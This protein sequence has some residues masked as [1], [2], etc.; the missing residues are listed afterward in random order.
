MFRRLKALSPLVLAAAALLLPAQAAGARDHGQGRRLFS[1]APKGLKVG[2]APSSLAVLE[3]EDGYDDLFVGTAGAE[4]IEEIDNHDGRLTRP[5][6]APV[7]ASPSALALQEPAFQG[8]NSIM[9]VSA[10]TDTARLFDLR[11]SRDG[12]ATFAPVG[13][14]AVGAGPAAVLAYGFE[15]TSE[16]PEGTLEEHPGAQFVVAN[17]GSDDLSLIGRSRDDR[18]SVVATV[19]VGDAPVALASDES[20]SQL[21][22]A[23][24]GS[25]TVTWLYDFISNGQ[26]Y[27]QTVAVGGEPV[28]VAIGDLVSG[29]YRDREAAVLDADS[30]RVLIVDRPRQVVG[31]PF[32][33]YRVVASYAAGRRPVALLAADLDERQGS[34]LAVVDSGSRGVRLLLNRGAGRFVDGGA[35]PAGRDPVA[36]API[37]YGPRF[38]PDLAIADRGSDELRFLVHNEFGRC[39]GRPARLRVG[40]AGRDDFGGSDEP[41]EMKGLAGDDRLAAS[42]GDDCIRGEAGEDYL[43]GFGGDD[44]LWPGPGKDEADGGSG[45]DTIFAAGGGADLVECGGGDDTAYVDRADRVRHCERER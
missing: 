2:D 10:A 20:F 35:Y 11:F 25:G 44:R 36:I 7:G 1:L 45:D 3:T 34:D 38:G 31:Q 8:L 9:A 28:A 27:S 14:V 39:N 40:T 6:S 41:E 18:L 19:P 17:R 4:R 23:N 16:T 26:I 42:R 37:E 21:W 30:E 33:A 22:V 5:A 32:E 43:L 12:K 24:S 13:T 15:I 29:D